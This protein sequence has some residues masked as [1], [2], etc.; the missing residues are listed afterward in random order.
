MK[1]WMK[2][3]IFEEDQSENTAHVQQLRTLHV[4]VKYK[5]HKNNVGVHACYISLRDIV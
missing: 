5:G 4:H 2:E 1:E 3:N